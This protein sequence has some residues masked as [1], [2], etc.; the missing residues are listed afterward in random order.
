VLRLKTTQFVLPVPGTVAVS[1]TP[2]LKKKLPPLVAPPV[3][4]FRT[5]ATVT[6]TF[7]VTEKELASSTAAGSKVTLP[8]TPAGVVAQIAPFTL[9]FA[10]AKYVAMISYMSP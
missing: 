2:V 7:T 9:P 8:A 5:S 3:V 6:F 1:V 4:S 10:R